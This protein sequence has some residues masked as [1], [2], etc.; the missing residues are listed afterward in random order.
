MPGLHQLLSRDN[1]YILRGAAI[2]FIV[3]HNF[4]HIE[5][6][7]FSVENEMSFSVDN[8]DAFFNSLKNS[9]HFFADFFS[10]LGW[11]GVPVFV[12]LTG[13][14]ISL[15]KPP[16]SFKESTSFIKRNYI[17]LLVLMLPA[18]L[19]FAGLDVIKGDIWPTLLKRASYLT[20]LANFVYPYVSCSP[21]V[22]WYFGLT[23]Q[24][25][26]LWALFGQHF[27]ARNLSLW[28]IVLIAG[29]YA[30]CTFGTPNALSIYRHCFT[31][32]LPVF[33]IGVWSGKN[34]GNRFSISIKTTWMQIV[35]LVALLCMILLMSR[36]MITWLFIPI[37]SLAWF[38]IIGLLIMRSQLLSKLFNWIGKLSAC[39]FVCHPIARTIVINTIYPRLSILLINVLLYIA[40][41]IVMALLYDKLYKWLLSKAM[42]RTMQIVNN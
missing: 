12:F 27:N 20:L 25:Y 21:G 11:I 16:I 35:L 40:I 28:S 2:V 9:T 13:Y 3:L 4:L 32:W 10:H 15:R 37:V 1:S 19:F 31:G 42:P 7:G 5:L 6:F 8:A 14:G 41:T 23:F 38:I 26:L 33:A 39:I 30:L 36:W 24:L 29:L 18:V 17:K 34:K 22:Y